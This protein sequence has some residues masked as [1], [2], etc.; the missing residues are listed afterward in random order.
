MRSL[1]IVLA[2]PRNHAI[3]DVIGDSSIILRFFS[4]IDQRHTDFGKGRSLAI[5]AA[6]HALEQAGFVLPEPIYRI[7]VDGRSLLD[8]VSAPGVASDQVPPKTRRRPGTML[9]MG[10]DTGPDS[11]VEQFVTEERDVSREPDLLDGRR[12]VE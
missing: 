11:A 8:P 2:D 4:W 6:K 12:P 9:P 5:Q 1:P 10:G 7:R 3:I